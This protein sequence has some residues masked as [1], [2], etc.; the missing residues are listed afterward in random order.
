MIQ[1]LI[2]ETHETTG[3]PGKYN[4]HYLLAESCIFKNMIREIAKVIKE[5]DA[6]QRNKPLNYSNRGPS[7]SHKS[8]NVLEKVSIDLIGLHLRGAVEPTSY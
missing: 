2:K 5:C 6:Y 3:H 7:S 1:Q 8:G 4:T